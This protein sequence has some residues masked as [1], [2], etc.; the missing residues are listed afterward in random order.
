MIIDILKAF[1]V[2]GALCAVGQLL[3]DF[4]KLTPARILTGYVVTGVILSAVGLYK[5]IAEFAGAGATVPLTGFGH[6]LAEGIRKTIGRDG[7]LG[8]FTGGLTAAAGGVT[9]A[10]LFGLIASLIFKQKDKL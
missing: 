9:A 5:P 6:L 1:L 2:G 4:T 3:I 8:I 10:L 7:F